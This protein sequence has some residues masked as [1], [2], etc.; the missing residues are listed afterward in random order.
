MLLKKMFFS[1]DKLNK[2]EEEV[3][4]DTYRREEINL[5]FALV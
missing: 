2:K 4:S 1:D 3:D 5:S